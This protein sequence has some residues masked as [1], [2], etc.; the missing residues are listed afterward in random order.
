MN[1]SPQIHNRQSIRLKGHDYAS[2][3]KYYLT[4]CIQNRL[5]LLGDVIDDKLVLNDAGKMVIKWYYEIENKYPDKKCHNMVVMPN[6]FHCIIE[7]NPIHESNIHVRDTHE[8]DAHG[9][10]SLRGCP[11]GHANNNSLFGHV[12]KK[13]NASIFDVMDW[14]KT[15]T[16]NEYIRG[17]KQLGWKRFEQRLWQKRYWDHIIRNNIDYSRINKYI[18]D[19]PIKWIYDK[20]NP[21]KINQDIL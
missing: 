19:N 17:V 13:Y 2:R 15:M 11:D 20:L 6:H 8:W 7:N 9:G 1:Y 18:D 4:I 5:C 12:N 16:T 14:F 10:T 21:L 3:G